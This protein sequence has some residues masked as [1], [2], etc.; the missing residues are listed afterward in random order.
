MIYVQADPLEGFDP[1]TNDYHIYLSAGD[2]LLPSVSWKQGDIYQLINP[3][4]QMLTRNNEQI[5]WKQNIEVLAQDGHCRTYTLYFYFTEPLST[6]TDLLNIYL[7]GVPLSGFNPSQYTYRETVA[8]G[9]SMPNIFVEKADDKQIVDIDTSTGNAIITV[10][11]EDA[12]YQ[13]TY[14]IYFTYLK[15]SYAYLEGIY[16]DGVLIE[17]FQ[18]D[19]FDYHIILPYA[20]TRMPEFTYQIGKE[21]QIVDVETITLADNK[22]THIFTVTAPDEESATAYNVLVEVSLNDNNRLQ[23]LLVK[24]TEVDNFHADTLDYTIYY[25]IG[26]STADFAT[27]DDIVAIAEDNNA[28]VSINPNGTDFIIQVVAADGVSTR[29]YTLKQVILLS[30]NNR[31]SAIYMDDVMLRGFD[32]EVLE[33]VYYVSD[34]QPNIV[35]VAEDSSA[36]IEY[37]IYTVDPPYY[38]Y[39]IAEDGSERVYTIHI[40]LSTISTSQ[41]PS[42]YDVLMKHIPGSNDII[43]ATTRKNISVAVYNTD[44]QLLFLSDVPASSQNDI[45]TINNTAGH[46]QLVDVLTP[47]TTFTLPTINKCYF[48][49]FFENGKRKVASGKLFFAR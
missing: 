29:V 30:A 8:E 11:A 33:Y 48:Y 47:M 32:P 41:L 1:Y 35:A 19:S 43:F 39:V 13:S 34:A 6:N 42:A 25:P 28:I 5:G 16:Q 21:G 7:D 14:I 18:P 36:T 23:T 45:I 4:S 10:T 37:G 9:K 12:S 44:G 3:T 17:G 49:V 24:G 22:L 27:I 15:S 46:T 2:T 20:T 31:L 38:I 40:K 26:S